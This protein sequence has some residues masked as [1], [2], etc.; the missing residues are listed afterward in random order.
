MASPGSPPLLLSDK[1]TVRQSAVQGSTFRNFRAERRVE[2]GA[3]TQKAADARGAR[4]GRAPGGIA[5]V[6]AAFVSNC[7]RAAARRNGKTPR[8]CSPPWGMPL[9]PEPTSL[10]P[11]SQRRSR[12]LEGQREGCFTSEGRAGF[13]S[14]IPKLRALPPSL[15][16]ASSAVMRKAPSLNLLLKAKWRRH[17]D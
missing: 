3:G 4:E 12:A 9:Q 13:W 2:Q 15:A 8:S 11:S 16:R 14:S 17:M 7:D 1:S 6:V 10:R 5:G